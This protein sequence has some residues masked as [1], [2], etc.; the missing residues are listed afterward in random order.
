MKL[1]PKKC[2][3]GVES[4]KLLEFMVSYRGI[5]ANSEK[6]Q[7]IVQMRSPRSLNQMQ[8]LT[9]RLTA[10]NRFISKATDK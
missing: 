7:S 2:A 3:F 8:S 9:G 5:E 10:L 6:I 4:R 1:N